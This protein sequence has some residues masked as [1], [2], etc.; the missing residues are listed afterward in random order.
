MA[1]QYQIMAIDSR[2][3]QTNPKTEEQKPEP[4]R[5]KNELVC[6]S[7][8]TKKVNME[9]TS[10]KT[11]SQF[12]KVKK[13]NSKSSKLDQIGKDIS[14]EKQQIDSFSIKPSSDKEN[15]NQITKNEVKNPN[16]TSSTE[17]L[18]GDSSISDWEHHFDCNQ[19]EKLEDLKKSRTSNDTK[20][21]LDSKNNNIDS[22]HSITEELLDNSSISNWEHLYHSNQ[23]EKLEDLEKSRTSSDTKFSLDSKNNNISSS[24]F[25]PIKASK[26][27]SWKSVPT[28]QL[29]YDYDDYNQ[30]RNKDLENSYSFKENSDYHN[31][32]IRKKIDSGLKTNQNEPLNSDPE[33]FYDCITN[34]APEKP[35]T[36]KGRSQ[37]DRVEKKD[38]KK[39]RK[40][41]N[42]QTKPIKLGYTT[43]KNVKKMSCNIREFLVWI[44][45]DPHLDLD[46]T[47]NTIEFTLE[48]PKSIMIGQQFLCKNNLDTCQF[49]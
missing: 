5:P 24:H 7:P 6:P 11:V 28:N 2:D 40:S 10:K 20:S 47:L 41:N 34:E 33:Y 30:G 36:P 3:T 25:R 42:K 16:F 15:S 22:S 46:L 9:K 8:R 39:I 38:Y 17:E 19:D 44:I 48:I 32:Y 14:S 29:Q 23:D 43:Q 31:N 49:A 18:L 13:S 35:P 45:L 12:T 26:N 21:T 1:E 4:Q 37:F 27:K